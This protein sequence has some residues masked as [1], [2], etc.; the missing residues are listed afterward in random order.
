MVP[1]PPENRI[2]FSGT[3]LSLHSPVAGFGYKPKRT[4]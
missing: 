2:S 1:F 3:R 4:P